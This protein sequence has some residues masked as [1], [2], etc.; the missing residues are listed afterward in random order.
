MY[1]Q[2]TPNNTKSTAA[3][4]QN[5]AVPAVGNT[6]FFKDV[7]ANL[8]TYATYIAPQITS[9]EIQYTVS[10][11]F[12]TSNGACTDNSLK[13]YYTYVIVTDTNNIVLKEGAAPLNINGVDLKYPDINKPR[14]FRAHYRTI[15]VNSGNCYIYNGNS[16]GNYYTLYMTTNEC[17]GNAYRDK[18]GDG[19]GDI[20][21][22]TLLCPTPPV[23]YVL[24]YN[25][26]NDN[27]P[28]IKGEKTWYR[29]YDGDG[30]GNNIDDIEYSV[31]SCTQIDGFVG[32]NLDCDD[33]DKTI[34]PSVA[35]YED[36]DGDGFGESE[37][38]T[39]ACYKPDG[40]VKDSTDCNDSN[41]NV[42]QNNSWYPDADGDGDGQADVPASFSGCTNPN[43]RLAGIS[44]ASSN[45]DCDDTNPNINSLTQEVLGNNVDEN[46]DG[47]N[48]IN[49][50]LHF[51]FDSP[52]QVTIPSSNDFDFSNDFTIEAWIK[53]NSNYINIIQKGND[54]VFGTDI[55]DGK[56][57]L[58]YISDSEARYFSSLPLE[59]NKWTHVALSVKNNVITFY[60][61][62]VADVMNEPFSTSSNNDPIIIGTGGDGDVII[63]EFRLWTSGRSTQQIVAN[64]DEY[65]ILND[66]LDLFAYYTF[67]Q[68]QPNADNISITSLLDLS[69]N[70]NNASLTNFTLLGN[71]SNFVNGALG[72]YTDPSL[73]TSVNNSQDN[74]TLQLYP[75]PIENLATV[76]FIAENTEVI[77]INIYDNQG[78]Q[79]SSNQYQNLAIGANELKINTKDLQSGVYI[80][81][82]KTST[83]VSKTKAII[84]H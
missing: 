6:N 20:N 23:G 17:I 52:N 43:A 81:E 2:C 49:N 34:N 41:I 16:A 51:S 78:K 83:K 10:S 47:R 9:T 7:S 25:D 62:G 63:D 15:D 61:N 58:Y 79:V 74:N 33:Y 68:G 28:N 65:L 21:E 8:G 54:I 40:F 27:D 57:I 82:L 35:W 13:N 44:F 30:Y 80:V 46:C 55:S 56:H 18:D 11:H 29:D 70:S 31:L 50:S 60:V 32:N 73:V 4:S 5:I 71:K 67:D 76:T 14:K 24:N 69:L 38:V 48:F 26:C 59:L 45:G 77:A 19:F 64:K 84:I 36:A 72:F 66:R 53:F 1:A 12:C 39:Y 3:N 75:N 42:N 22:S 37:I